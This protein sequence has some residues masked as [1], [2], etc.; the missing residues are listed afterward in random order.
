MLD[1][2]RNIAS[3]QVSTTLGRL[4]K[5]NILRSDERNS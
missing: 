3:G 5:A 2:L 4:G 1:V